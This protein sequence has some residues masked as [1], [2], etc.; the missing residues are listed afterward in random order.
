MR[1]IAI[2]INLTTKKRDGVNLE[3][4]I[5]TVIN[6]I[7][8]QNNEHF[9]LKVVQP[10]ERPGEEASDDKETNSVS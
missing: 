7:F 4:N 8:F 3:L 2:C 10:K 9:L 1:N 5:T 6:M